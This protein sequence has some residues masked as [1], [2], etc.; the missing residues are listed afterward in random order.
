MNRSVE[1]AP[2]L[3]RSMRIL[4]LILAVLAPLWGAQANDGFHSKGTIHATWIMIWNGSTEKSW[5]QPG[6]YHGCKVLVNGEWQ[7]INWND[8]AHIRT[9]FDAMKA[10]GMNAIIV[11]FT[12]GF[13]WQWQAKFVQ[14]LCREHAMKFA[15]AFNPRAGEG[16][17]RGCEEVWKT[18]ASPEAADAEAYLHRDGKPLVVL[19]TWR[20]GYQASTAA[21]G[22]F[23]GRFATVW[24]SG[25]DSDKDK[26]GWQ[27]EPAVGPVASDETMFVTGSVKFDSPKTREDRWRRHLSW[28]DYGFAIARRSHPKVLMVGSFDDVH[29]RNAWMVAD[30]KN[31]KTSW[32]MRDISGALSTEAYYNRVRAWVRDGK[33]P[34]IAG[35]VIR[36]GA[37]QVNAS[38]RRVLGVAENRDPKSPAVL[39]RDPGAPD[40]LVWFYHLGNNEYRMIKLNA[41][42]PFEGGGAT[43]FINWDSDAD[44][45]RWLLRKEGGKLVIIHKAAGEALDWE[46]DRVITKPKSPSSATQRW[47]LTEEITL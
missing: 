12:N 19:Y 14:Q 44:A 34:V 24:A 18:Y 23:R 2:T 40:S 33:A 20:K 25:E 6:D 5:W 36:D 31:A 26:W 45:Q 1:P 35:G 37:Y 21:T 22:P 47:T 43:V 17:E 4:P 7:S 30:T 39:R 38:D 32:Q 27:L 15:V 42:L 29:E 46:G 13:R 28:L 8:R 41:G 9:Y 10:A 16:M 11:D 3:H